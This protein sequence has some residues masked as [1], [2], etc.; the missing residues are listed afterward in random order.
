MSTGLIRQMKGGLQFDGIKMERE[1][2]IMYTPILQAIRD[3]IDSLRD[4]G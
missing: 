2:G 3:E 1:P 4:S